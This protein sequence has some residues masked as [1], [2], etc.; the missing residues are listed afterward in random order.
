MPK[1]R[2][3]AHDKGHDNLEQIDPSNDNLRARG[4]T[5]NHRGHDNEPPRQLD[6]D[7]D[8]AHNRYTNEPESYAH[9]PRHR[10][11]YADH[12]RFGYDDIRGRTR[13]PINRHGSFR[14]RVSTFDDMV[15]LPQ[16]PSHR[17]HEPYGARQIAWGFDRHPTEQPAIRNRRVEFIDPAPKQMVLRGGPIQG[18]DFEHTIP[19]RDSFERTRHDDPHHG[20][21]VPTWGTTLEPYVDITRPPSGLEK[22]PVVEEYL[23]LWTNVLRKHKDGFKVLKARIARQ[24][25]RSTHMPRPFPERPRENGHSRRRQISRPRGRSQRVPLNESI[26]AGQYTDATPPVVDRLNSM[27]L[28]NEIGRPSTQQF[29][30][31]SSTALPTQLSLPVHTKAR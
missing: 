24:P 10:Q 16:S 8:Q 11:S 26:Q 19:R 17:R 6:I 4:H 21:G 9:V 31:R 25:P 27:Q 23:R 28:G 3:K 30:D 15:D 18:S 14:H 22:L 7:W 13:S 20:R 2:R 29:S 5:R 1:K 12:G